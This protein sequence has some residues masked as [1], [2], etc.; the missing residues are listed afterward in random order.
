MSSAT[1]A[2]LQ[3]VAKQTSYWVLFAVSFSH[4]LNDLMQALLPA[5]Y[6]L[7]RDLY[8]LDFTQIGLITLVNQMT[9]SLLQPLVGHI[10][11]KR[12][13]PY[14]LPIA[15]GFTLVGLVLLAYADGFQALLIASALIG[16]GSAIFHPEA[17]RVARM[18]SGGRLGFAQSLFQV[19]GNFGTAIG[20]LMAA[21]IILPRGQGSVA[22]Y[23]IVALTAIVVL[24]LVGTWY[25]AQ[26]RAIKAAPPV[27]IEH[28]DVSRAQIIGAVAV[29]GALLLAK[30][31]YLSSMTS[32]YTFFM[33]EKFAITPNEAQVY[34]F[35]FLG[36]VAAG[37]FAGGPIGDRIGRKAV[38]WVSM[39]GV[40]PFTLALPYANL[41][42][43]VLLSFFVG[44]IQASAFSAL[45]VY[46]QELVPGRVGMIAGMMFGF[47]FAMGALGAAILG[48]VADLTSIIFVFQ[49]CA[50]LPVL[51]FLTAF[52]PKTDV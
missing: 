19:G 5:V 45:V 32:F 27:A 43:T 40:L 49:I 7:L 4:F 13:M 18:A 30:Y 48:V 15:M 29:I 17:S 21:F 22:W 24:Y 3:P 2:G 42:I 46:A 9:A 14:S 26:N 12:P 16:V 33:M 31:V 28:P 36:A 23:S 51:G 37:T 34:L 47:A 44:V 10:T 35:V 39:V 11:D 38:I 25:S 50:F 6:P 1:T 52:L 20:P 41:P 8:A